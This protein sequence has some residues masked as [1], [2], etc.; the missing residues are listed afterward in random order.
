MHVGLWR[1]LFYLHQRHVSVRHRCCSVDY[2][3]SMQFVPPEL[4]GCAV[5]SYWVVAKLMKIQARSLAT[6]R[7]VKEIC[8]DPLK[9]ANKS[10]W[11]S[12][13]AKAIKHYQLLFHAYNTLPDFSYSLFPTI[14]FGK[15]LFYIAWSFCLILLWEL[16]QLLL[17]CI[18]LLNFYQEIKEPAL[19]RKGIYLQEREMV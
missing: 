17:L 3:V 1:T 8:F 10:L 11:P 5:K 2:T 12:V 13:S 14:Q 7:E 9:D 19:I 4:S 18:Y 16:P 6:R 15:A